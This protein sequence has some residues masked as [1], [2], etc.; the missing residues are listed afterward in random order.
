M[1]TALFLRIMPLR[2]VPPPG[3]AGTVSGPATVCQGQPGVIYSVPD[4]PNATN[5]IWSLPAGASIVSGANTKTITV[6]YSSIAVPG[7]I[8]VYG[9]N[10]CGTGAISPS[11]SITVTAL[12]VAPGIINGPNV[13]CQGQN[14][15][16]LYCSNH[17]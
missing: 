13:V 11:Y 15:C 16:K 6:N 8:T 9:Q 12:P 17:R 4:I 14:G 5:Y 1:V 3:A 10:S 2:L 7:N